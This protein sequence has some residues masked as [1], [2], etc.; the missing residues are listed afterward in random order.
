MRALR[1]V[2]PAV[3]VA[4]GVAPSAHAA[5]GPVEEVATGLDSPRHLE[6]GDRG[7]LFVAEA[8]LGGTES[9]ASTA[10]RASRASA[11]PGA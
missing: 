7:D 5:G 4:L 10:P 6:F 2:L 8:G 3:V 9:R 1:F 11:T